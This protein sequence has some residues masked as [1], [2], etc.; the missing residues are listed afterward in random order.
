MLPAE[1]ASV[2]PV[3]GKRWRILAP[4]RNAVKDSCSRI[5][6]NSG[7]TPLIPKSHDSGYK[8]IP[9]YLTAKNPSRRY[10]S[11]RAGIG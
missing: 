7:V 8:P 3:S 4:S 10:P 2:G 11:R 6:E 1:R 5:R 9:S